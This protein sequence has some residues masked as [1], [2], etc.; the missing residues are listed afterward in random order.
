MLALLLL[1]TITKTFILSATGFSLLDA[2][3]TSTSVFAVPKTEML[4][5]DGDRLWLATDHQTIGANASYTRARYKSDFFLLNAFGPDSPDSLCNATGRTENI[6]GNQMPRIPEWKAGAWAQY[7]LPLGTRGKIDLFASWSWIDV[8]FF[9]EIELATD[10]APAYDRV[11]PRATWFSA[12]ET[13]SVA[14]FVNNL[15]KEIGIRQTIRGGEAGN[16]LRSGMTTD[17]RLGGL[18]VRYRF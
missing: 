4:G 18:E 14:A 17:P 1:F 8:V 10:R 13:R 15:F 3:E 9:S 6:C 16:Y 11:A 12:D 2:D 5:F 7:G